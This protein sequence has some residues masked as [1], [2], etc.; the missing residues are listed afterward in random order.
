MGMSKQ[1]PADLVPVTFSP[2]V[3]PFLGGGGRGVVK[4]TKPGSALGSSIIWH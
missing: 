2:G 3:S 4:N 1:S